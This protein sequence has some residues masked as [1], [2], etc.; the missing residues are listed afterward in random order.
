MKKFFVVVPVCLILF[1]ASCATPDSRAKKNEAAFNS[2][3]AD[4]QQ[5]V[6]AGKVDVGF[7]PDMV[8]VALGAPD[9]VATR[10]TAQGVAEVWVYFDNNPKFSLGIG[11]VSGGRHSAV[12]GGMV[13][14]DDSWRDEEMLR[15]IFEGGRVAAIETRK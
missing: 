1:A 2:W 8:R 11:M 3:P 6:R 13:V 5:K 12:G 4:V 10:T 9:R 15:V 7:T 14:G